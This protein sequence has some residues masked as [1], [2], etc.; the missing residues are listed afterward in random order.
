MPDDGLRVINV[1]MDGNC[2]EYEM[3]SGVCAAAFRARDGDILMRHAASG[4]YYTIKAG[5]QV[6]VESHALSVGPFF[7]VGTSAIV[8]EVLLWY[9]TTRT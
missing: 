6:D 4:A 9:G 3:P 7:F 1:T 8:L 2:T 5:A